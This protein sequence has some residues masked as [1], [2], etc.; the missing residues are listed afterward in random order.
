MNHSLF[1]ILYQLDCVVVL[2]V[3][4]CCVCGVGWCVGGVVVVVCG[5]VVFWWWL[6]GG[7]GV[8]GGWRGGWVW[9]GLAAV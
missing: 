1:I 8:V 4:W 9:G 7:V 3:V 5:V 2:C 6:G